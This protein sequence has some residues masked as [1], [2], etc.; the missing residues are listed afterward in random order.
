MDNLIDILRN[1]NT[2]LIGISLRASAYLKVAISIT[3]YIKRF[4]KIP[5]V[6]G[7][8]HPTLVPEKCIEFADIVCRGEGEYPLLELVDNI[9]KQKE[10]DNIPN[11]WIRRGKEIET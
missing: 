5:I 8:L 1:T 10:I 4:L 2:D 11:L 6:W 7:G 9:S 3:E